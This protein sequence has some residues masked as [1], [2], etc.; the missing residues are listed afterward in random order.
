MGS[1]T[2]AK[3]S[4]TATHEFGHA[5]GLKDLKN[6]SNKGTLM[7]G[8]SSRTVTKPQFSDVTGAKEAVK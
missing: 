4:G 6:T 8:K 1:R 3:N 2:S 7:Y 5:I